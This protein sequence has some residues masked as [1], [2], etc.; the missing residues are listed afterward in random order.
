MLLRVMITAVV[1][2]CAPGAYAEHIAVIGTGEVATV[3]GKKWAAA[4]HRITYG[5]RTPDSAKAKQAVKDTGANASATTPEKATAAADIVLLAVPSPTAKDVVPKLGNLAG[6]IVI[7]P[8]NYYLPVD[9]Y[10][11]PLAGPSLAQQVQTWLP[12]AKVVK[13]FNTFAMKMIEDPDIAGGPITVPVAGDDLAAKA[14]VIKLAQDAGLEALDMGP[15]TAATFIE[16]ME[17]LYLGYRMYN[18]GKGKGFEFHLR[19]VPDTVFP[20]N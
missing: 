16:G 5:S 4:G 20:V 19:P 10:P 11:G 2:F 14:R 8:M 6:K 3:L 1:L 12:G 7:D 15:L 9:G 17:Q 18:R 13:A